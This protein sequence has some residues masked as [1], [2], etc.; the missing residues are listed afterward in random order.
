MKIYPKEE[1]I[2]NAILKASISTVEANLSLLEDKSITDNEL[3]NVKTIVEALNVD[4][5]DKKVQD[6][7]LAI[8]ASNFRHPALLYARATLTS[9]V[10]NQ[11]LEVFT[12]KETWAARDTCINQPV[13]DEHEREK[14][15]GHIIGRECKDIKTGAILDEDKV[16]TDTFDLNV[17]FVIY[18]SVLDQDGTKDIK[19]KI[20]KGSIGT[21][22]ECEINDFCYGIVDGETIYIVD[23]NEDTSFLSEYLTCFGGPGVYDGKIV[24]RVLKDILFI[25]M[26][27][28]TSPANKRSNYIIL[29][30]S[31][32]KSQIFSCIRN[33]RD[34]KT[35][36]LKS[37][38]ENR[39]MKF[40]NLDQAVG[41][42]EK[43][44]KELTDL[45]AA[46]AEADKKIADA[47]KELEAAKAEL[48]VAKENL[49]AT[50][51]AKTAIETEKAEIAKASETAKAALKTVSDELNVIKSK[52]KGVNRV[53]ELK[54]LGR[55]FE[56]EDEAVEKYGKMADESYDE[57]VAFAK[58][59]AVT[60]PAEPET[61]NDTDVLAAITAATKANDVKEDDVDVLSKG[62][63]DAVKS[64]R[65][66]RKRPS[67]VE[68]KA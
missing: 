62:L 66:S 9:S 35:F 53:A 14:I 40:E 22:M 20:S 5:L 4:K 17:D 13:N 61:K 45:K 60:K 47:T 37:N 57:I 19:E 16:P 29:Y 36:F 65:A 11:N 7:I 39:L 63:A 30:E 8:K 3:N 49:Q 46:K 34:K 32:D 51:D 58:Q 64:V 55:K 43:Q 2:K 41:Y 54:S 44:E 42:I 25:G 1:K 12:P 26:G 31:D 23:R 28:V 21:S 56:K 68:D 38:M 18:N 6:E 27:A 10:M 59:N 67:L 48:T 15:I 52:T 50:I 24:A 33:R